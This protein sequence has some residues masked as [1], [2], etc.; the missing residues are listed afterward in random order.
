[1][2]MQKIIAGVS[3]IAL[4]LSI[5]QAREIEEYDVIVAG[6]SRVVDGDTVVVDGTT[7]RLKGVDAAEMSTILGVESKR[8]MEEIVMGQDLY[9]RLT[10]E[11]TH[12]REVG[13]CFTKDDVDINRAIIERGGALSCPRYDA[14]YIKYE[15]PEL[16]L[17]QSRARYCTG[18]S[19]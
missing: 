16:L 4:L 14:R 19:R 11:R 6:P 2:T 15:R 17:A 9:C 10:G 13:Y 8:I 5:A 1:M 3:I 7:V 18:R 12:R